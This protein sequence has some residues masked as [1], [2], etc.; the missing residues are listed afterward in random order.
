MTAVMHVQLIL[1]DTIN[2]VHKYYSQ[3][4]VFFRVYGKEVSI[5]EVFL[6]L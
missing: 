1:H 5:Q 6:S 2:R 4:I 3:F